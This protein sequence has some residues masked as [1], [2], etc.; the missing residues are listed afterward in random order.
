M[1]SNKKTSLKDSFLDILEEIK[2][3]HNISQDLKTD[4]DFTLDI[5]GFSGH[6]H[7]FDLIVV[8]NGFEI[9]IEFNP[10][11][12]ESEHS[13]LNFIDWRFSDEIFCTKRIFIIYT[14]ISYS[15]IY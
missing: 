7:T 5:N 11:V 2:T 15:Y 9:Y 6:N 4:S 12:S 10:N 1:L 3:T 13:Y 8:F 14:P